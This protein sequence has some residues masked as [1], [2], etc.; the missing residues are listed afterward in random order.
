MRLALANAEQAL[1][2][3]E[4]ASGKPL[5]DLVRTDKRPVDPQLRTLKTEVTY[6]RADLLRLER[7]Q[8]SDAEALEQARQRLAKAE[9]QLHDHSSR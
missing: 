8:G 1:H 4:A 5:P 7:R 2:A 6:A 3:A 9:Q